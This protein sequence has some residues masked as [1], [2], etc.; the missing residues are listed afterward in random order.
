MKN[1]HIIP[2][3]HN[4]IKKIIFN[5]PKNISK[6]QELPVSL[7]STTTVFTSSG[8]FETHQ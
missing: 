7:F 6:I 4:I 5:N 2:T 1:N 8:I 3:T